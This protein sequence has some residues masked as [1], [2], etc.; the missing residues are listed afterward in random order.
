MRTKVRFGGLTIGGKQ[1]SYKKRHKKK[2]M[3]HYPG[4][5]MGPAG[6]MKKRRGR[7]RKFAAAEKARE[8]E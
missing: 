5:G 4:G 6:H 7:V 1:M 8:M 3:V 2:K